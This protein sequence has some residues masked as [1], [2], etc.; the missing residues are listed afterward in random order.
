MGNVKPNKNLGSL[1]DAYSLLLEEIPHDLVIV[2][3]KDGFITGDNVVISRAA[4]MGARVHFTGHLDETLLRQYVSHAD[5]FVFPSLYEGFGLPPL[6]AMAAGCPVIA[7]NAASLPE[8]CG[9]AV[10]YCDPYDANDIA[11][12][13]KLVL[14]DGNKRER[15]RVK[16]FE[17]AKMFTWEKCAIE[18]LPVI[19]KVI[20]K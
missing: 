2:G 12:K 17:H 13:I 14:A 4:G 18:T 15:M 9:D 20:S 7:S 1:V 11:E 6:E 5:I 8:V 16:G 19:A 3:K 10:T